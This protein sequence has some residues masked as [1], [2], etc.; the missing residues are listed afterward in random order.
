MKF[1]ISKS[2]GYSLGPSDFGSALEVLGSVDLLQRRLPP[3]QPFAVPPDEL[4]LP[5]E[6][7]A[8]LADLGPQR[9]LRPVSVDVQPPLRIKKKQWAERK[10]MVSVE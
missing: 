4:V 8:H 6:F 10:Y 7:P 3:P 1:R 9:A 2:K 5:A